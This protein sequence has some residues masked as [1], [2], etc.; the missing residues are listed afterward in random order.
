MF[1]QDLSS[2]SCVVVEGGRN[3]YDEPSSANFQCGAGGGYSI[4]VRHL[5]K[6]MDKPLCSG[7]PHNP[8][9]PGGKRALNGGIWY[10]KLETGW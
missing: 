1:Q 4:A 2:F 3:I 5:R 9:W 7:E 6:N 8:Y 10:G